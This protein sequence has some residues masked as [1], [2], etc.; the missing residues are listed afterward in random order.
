MR[1]V[2][3]Y[4]RDEGQGFEHLGLRFTEIG[5]YLPGQLDSREVAGTLLQLLALGVG[6]DSK[7]GGEDITQRWFGGNR[8]RA[9]HESPTFPRRAERRY[10]ETL[11]PHLRAQS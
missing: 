8:R 3:A 6:I 7:S 1:G 9:A 10:S 4:C 11:Q 5:R 2:K